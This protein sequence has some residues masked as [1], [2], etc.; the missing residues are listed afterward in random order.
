MRTWTKRNAIVISAVRR[1]IHILYGITK[2]DGLSVFEG[3]GGGVGVSGNPT[4]LMLH[5]F[6]NFKRRIQQ[7]PVQN[8]AR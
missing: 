2:N 1:E 4:P 7:N 5:I 6:K 8:S 3:E